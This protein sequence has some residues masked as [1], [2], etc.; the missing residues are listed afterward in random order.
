MQLKELQKLLQ[1]IAIW[2]I[3]FVSK[4]KKYMWNLQ[5]LHNLNFGNDLN[6]YV[7]QIQFSFLP[8]R[9]LQQFLWQLSKNIPD[10]YLALLSSLTVDFKL[11]VRFSLASFLFHCSNSSILTS[12]LF[13]SLQSCFTAPTFSIKI[14]S[15]EMQTVTKINRVYSSIRCNQQ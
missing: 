15:W 2:N 14:W 1:S 7:K 6:S 3:Y 5:I 9:P 11:L 13:V 12:R 8:Q 4:L 10:G